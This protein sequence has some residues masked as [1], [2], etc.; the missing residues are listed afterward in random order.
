M[1]KNKKFSPLTDRN[2]APIHTNK[3]NDT[4]TDIYNEQIYT[5]NVFS[6]IS[7]TAIDNDKILAFLSPFIKTGEKFFKNDDFD[8]EKKNIGKYLEKNKRIK[9]QKIQKIINFLI[10]EK[11][12]QNNPDFYTNEAVTRII[13]DKKYA[14]YFTR[15]IRAIY[16]GKISGGYITNLN[17]FLGVFLAF[18]IIYIIDM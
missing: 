18:Y 2:I 6:K 17:R 8:F 16:R 7:I 4:E 3:I 14:K 10:F 15:D 5:D 13:T 11:I 12:A 1:K 9:N